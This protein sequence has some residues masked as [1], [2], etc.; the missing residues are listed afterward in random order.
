MT[1]VNDL[2]VA[3][4]VHGYD[5]VKEFYRHLAEELNWEPGGGGAADPRVAK[6]MAETLKNSE[7]LKGMPLLEVLKLAP[8]GTQSD[9]LSQDPANSNQGRAKGLGGIFGGLGREKKDQPKTSPEGNDSSFMTTTVEVTSFSNSAVD[10]SLFEV[11]AGYTQ[12]QA[13]PNEVFTRSQ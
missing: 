3:P 1:F 4:S 10:S 2:W 12:V 7:E 13:N 9:S 6:A 5:E 11:P 8:S